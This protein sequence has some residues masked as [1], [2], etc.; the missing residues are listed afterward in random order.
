[1]L[2]QVII[3]DRMHKLSCSRTVV[4]AAIVFAVTL[5]GCA[6]TVEAHESDSLTACTNAWNVRV[7]AI[8]WDA[9]YGHTAYAD[10]FWESVTYALAP[11]VYWN[12]IPFFGAIQPSG[13]IVPPNGSQPN[14]MAEEIIYAISAGIDYWAF[15]DYPPGSGLDKALKLYLATG[16]STK[17]KFALILNTWSYEQ[18]LTAGRTESYLR[19]VV[20]RL[21]DPRY[22]TVLGGRPLVY[23]TDDVCSSDVDANGRT[24]ASK[25]CSQWLYGEIGQRVYARKGVFPY[26]VLL[27]AGRDVAI[28]KELGMSAISVYSVAPEMVDLQT[29]DYRIFAARIQTVWN[30]AMSTV[31]SGTMGIVPFSSVGWDPSP[32]IDCPQWLNCWQASYVRRDTNGN[33]MKD[34]NGRYVYE[35]VRRGTA[36][37]IADHIAGVAQWTANNPGISP[38]RTMLVYAWNEFDE[39]GFVC[40]TL[41][42]SGNGIDASRIRALHQRLRPGC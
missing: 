5:A 27:S 23:A 41:Q 32:R 9:W 35:F 40:P 36:A 30:P 28:A 31:A 13:Q 16:L 14:R 26:F 42:A 25:Y 2:V 20:G 29:T 10:T 3:G 4:L 1:M 12:R 34:A 6:S 38:A 19:E 24:N 37:Q 15:L 22:E 8:R 17:I 7:G 18:A 39:G 11:R 21:T 33:L